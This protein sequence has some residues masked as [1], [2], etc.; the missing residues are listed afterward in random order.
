[1]PVAPPVPLRPAATIAPQPGAAPHAASALPIGAVAETVTIRPATVAPANAPE[2]DADADATNVTGVPA[3]DEVETAGAVAG[4][5]AGLAMPPFVVPTGRSRVQLVAAALVVTAIL[6]ALPVLLWRNALS[7]RGTAL[8]G[9]QT[10]PS[11]TVQAVPVLDER[12]ADNQ[13][14]WLNNPASTAWLIPNGYRLFAR[15]PGRFVSLAAPVPAPGT[16]RD[17]MVTASFHKVGGPAG[18]GYG[19]IL[20]DQQPATRDGVNQGGRYYVLAAGDR[21]EV[22]IWRRETDQFVD[23]VPWTPSDAVRTGDGTN[24]VVAIARDTS[25][26]LFVNGIR[27]ASVAD[28]ALSEGSVGIFVGGDLNEVVMDRFSVSTIK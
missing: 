7:N 13:R 25:L 16:F 6:V 22:G 5:V 10:A 14:N 18:G 27:V 20:R 12:F 4:G 28:R 26:T 8:L 15:Q 21:G 11:A 23:L 3:R 17:V 19:L 2:T 24:E 1:V 9:T